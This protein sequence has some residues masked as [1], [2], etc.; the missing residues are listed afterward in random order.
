MSYRNIGGGILS[1]QVHQ[2]LAGATD[3]VMCQKELISLTT[4]PKDWYKGIDEDVVTQMIGFTNADQLW[5]RS[6]P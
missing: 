2:A 4:S 1:G 6:K 5:E 3:L